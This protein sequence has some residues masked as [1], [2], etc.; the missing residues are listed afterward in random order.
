M[1][2]GIVGSRRRDTEEDR[3]Q[4]G[5][6]IEEYLRRYGKDLIIVSGAC[7]KGADNH[8][9]QIAKSYG[10]QLIEFPALVSNVNNTVL[11]REAHYERNT[12]IA[13]FSDRIIAQVAADRRGGTE[14]T[15]KKAHAFGKKVYLIDDEG[16]LV[17]D[18]APR[19][20]VKLNDF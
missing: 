9:A 3:R 8:A 1:R 4:V 15:I 14:D 16:K 7:P 18:A 5:V 19:R 12:S 20:E 11:Y 2:L 6:V 17:P 13:R 10:I